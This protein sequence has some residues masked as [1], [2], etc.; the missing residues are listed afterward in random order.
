M[1]IVKI[2]GGWDSWEEVQLPT[3]IFGS[4]PDLQGACDFVVTDF[5]SLLDRNVDE[6]ACDSEIVYSVSENLGQKN[7]PHEICWNIVCQFE[8]R[9]KHK[10]NSKQ[11]AK[12]KR[13][14]ANR[15]LKWLKNQQITEP[16]AGLATETQ[17]S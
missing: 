11:I 16:T 14:T 6:D 13:R 8:Y 5:S 1:F 12:K 10:L 3:R 17:K 7:I 9:P 15:V 2:E 4:F